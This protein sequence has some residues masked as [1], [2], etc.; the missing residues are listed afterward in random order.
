M[1]IV[2]LFRANIIDVSP[3]TLIVEVVGDEDKIDALQNLLRSFGIQEVMRT[4]SVAM[5]RGMDSAFETNGNKSARQSKPV[6][7]ETGSV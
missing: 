2:D 3:E 6:I 4:G 7:M 5:S 1:Q